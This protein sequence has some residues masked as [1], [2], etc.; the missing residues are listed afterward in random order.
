V[1]PHRYAL[2][3]SVSEPVKTGGKSTWKLTIETRPGQK[4]LPAQRIQ[5]AAY[6]SYLADLVDDLAK[7]AM[8]ALL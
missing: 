5:Q 8:A 3:V 4:H 2:P 7:K 1:V 6:W